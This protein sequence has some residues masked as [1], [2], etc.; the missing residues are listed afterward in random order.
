[1]EP[2]A[3][4]IGGRGR[5]VEHFPFERLDVRVIEQVVEAQVASLVRL[6]F[7]GGDRGVVDRR[8]RVT[9]PEP[10]ADADG[11]AG[12]S[13]VVRLASPGFVQVIGAGGE[14]IP[15]LYGAGNCIASP[16]RAAYYGA[17]GTIGPAMTF[18]YVAG[19]NA[20]KEPVSG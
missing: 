14:P 13:V 16:T 2:A 12:R 11:A 10:A 4:I 7:R 9:H 8:A 5:G 18:G 17:G 20:A 1:M 15:G 19:L 3:G 6:S